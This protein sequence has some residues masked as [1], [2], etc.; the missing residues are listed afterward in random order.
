MHWQVA[1]RE[2][3]RTTLVRR[4]RRGAIAIAV[5]TPVVVTAQQPTT[6]PAQPAAARPTTYTV[7]RGDNLWDL[8]KRFL[9]DP[10][11]W[12]RIY[13]LNT[14]LIRDPH[15][16]YPG[17]IL[18][19]PAPQAAAPAVAEAPAATK[20]TTPADTAAPPAAAVAQESPVDPNA[21]TIF[22]RKAQRRDQVPRFSQEPL[23]QPPP[24]VRLGEF[25]AA[26][27]VERSGRHRGVGRIIGSA[28][29]EGIASA[30]E[31]SRYPPYAKIFITPP[32]GA[33]VAVGDRYVAIATGPKLEGLGQV[34]IP[35]GIVRVTQAPRPGQA[36][37]AEV[38]RLFNE[39]QPGQQLVPYDSS[40]TELTGTPSP[41]TNGRTAK[42]QWIYNQPVL[43]SIQS[44][45]V[46]NLSTRDGV[47]IGDR[48]ELYRPVQK[49][50]EP[51]EPALPEIPIARASV[52]RVTPFATTVVLTGEEQPKIEPGTHV[53]VAAQMP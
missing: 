35:A 24:V 22:A 40:V 43:P 25:L 29:I 50:H 6:Q 17:E 45:L 1:R 4:L 7:K 2:R 18:T 46:V 19:L 14:S 5:L 3:V 30:A 41:V 49:S 33:P 38:E 27:Y 13:R 36:A 42:V 11:L 53:R 23:V 26:P 34:I 10:Y 9:N 32:A 51:G 21:P 48:F 31:P 16:I 20:I 47:K 12:P 52:V 39:V 44:Y 28:E 15:W 8:A 37:V